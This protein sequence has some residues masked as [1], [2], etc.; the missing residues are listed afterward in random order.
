MK[1]LDI[2]YEDKYLIIINKPNKILT[3]STLKEKENTLYNE[4]SNYVKKQHKS[5]KIFVVHRLDKDTSGLII[6]AKSI[7]VKNKLQSNW[8]NVIRKYYSIVHG[9]VNKDGLITSYLKENKYFYTYI[10]NSKDGVL[11]KLKYRVVKSNNNY[12]LLD[13]NILTGKKNQ[14]RVQLNSI[15]HPIVGDKKYG[16][17]DNSNI[18]CLH[19]YYLKFNHPINNKVLEFNINYPNYF[20]NFIK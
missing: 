2:V 4:V 13:I 12:S 7:L 14:I 17:K 11:A 1:K 9:K 15:N 8:N 5:N 3:I 18:L 10:T 16:I 20:N 6:F 19:A